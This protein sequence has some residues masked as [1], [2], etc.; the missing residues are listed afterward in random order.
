[1]IGLLEEE[2]IGVINKSVM[3]GINK[4]VKL[5]ETSLGFIPSHWEIRRLGTIGRF[6]KGG[7]ISRDELTTSYAS[8]NDVSAILYGD[9]YTKYNIVAENIINK[10]SKKTALKS[11]KL[12]KGDLLFTGSGETKEDIGKCVLFNSDEITYAGGDVIIFKQK[13]FDSNFISYSQNS[14]VA[15]YQKYNSAK[16][17]I[18]VHTYGSKLRDVAMPFPPSKDEQKQIVD[19]IDKECQK[20][21][22]A[23]SKARQEIDSIKEYQ[24]ALITDLV[25]GKRS[26]NT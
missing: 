9:I 3:Y 7:N 15:K 10:I 20:L 19:F 5:K 6:T 13:I 12:L 4:N 21:D 14:S 24:E 2:K 23:I 8:D 17:E 16:G 26:I 22:S 1:M 11:V 25:T 18:I